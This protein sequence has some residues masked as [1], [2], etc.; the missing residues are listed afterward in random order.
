MTDWSNQRYFEDVSEGDDVPEVRFPLVIQRM[1][2]EAGANRDF[3]AIHHN[4]ELA[5]AGGAPDMY[6][7]NSFLQGMWERTV[8]EYIGLD[9]MIRKIGPF[10]MRVFNPVGDAVLVRG[11]VTKKYQEGETNFVEIEMQSVSENN[12]NVTVGPGPVL[13]TLPSKD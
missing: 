5:Q 4:R 3:N 1:V 13:V 7:N 8:R 10:R 9:G 11:K 12:G 2:M 6:A